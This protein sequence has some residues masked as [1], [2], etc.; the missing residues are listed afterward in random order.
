MCWK[1]VIA[2]RKI[3]DE[4]L[5]YISNMIDVTFESTHGI[6]LVSNL[7]ACMLP[8]NQTTNQSPFL[9]CTIYSQAQTT[10][11][12]GTEEAAGS[13]VSRVTPE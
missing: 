3:N 4:L 8:T 13:G 9:L 10:G 5:C 2:K 11:G 6:I 12:K 1:C 7:S